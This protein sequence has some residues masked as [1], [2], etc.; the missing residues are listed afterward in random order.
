[1]IAQ[2]MNSKAK[3]NGY[4]GSLSWSG[5]ASKCCAHEKQ[6]QQQQRVFL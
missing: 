6:Q 1:M 2:K 4:K 5:R 3:F